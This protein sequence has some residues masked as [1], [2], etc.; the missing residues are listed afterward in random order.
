MSPDGKTA[1]AIEGVDGI[2]AFDATTGQERWRIAGSATPERPRGAIHPEVAFSADSEFVLLAP[3]EDAGSY[4]VS[5]MIRE[6]TWDAERKRYNTKKTTEKTVSRQV[7]A[8]RA[9]LQLVN[10]QTGRAVWKKSTVL[11]CM[12]LKMVF[13]W[14]PGKEPVL[15]ILKD[16]VM[17]A[18]I[19]G[20]AWLSSHRSE[21]VNQS[22]LVRLNRCH[23]GTYTARLARKASGCWRGLAKRTLPC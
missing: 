6:P 1:I 21:P 12:M 9:T 7:T 19:S 13:S 10:V 17:V 22:T 8:R 20:K 2:V 14:R 18:V 15:T 3:L 4:Q 23:S 11:S 16:R 5:F